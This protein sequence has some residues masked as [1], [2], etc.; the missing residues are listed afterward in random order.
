M[1]LLALTSFIL[2]HKTKASKYSHFF[3]LIN[4]FTQK[5]RNAKLI[6]INI[7][8]EFD[9]CIYA[10]ILKYSKITRTKLYF[11]VHNN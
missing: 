7:F 4:N 9:I 2:N 6:I 8:D 11:K 10:C 3:F 5:K 1:S